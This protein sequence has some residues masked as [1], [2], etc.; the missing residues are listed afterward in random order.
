M[1]ILITGMTSRHVGSER[2]RVKYAQASAAL[3]AVLESVPDEMNENPLLEVEQRPAEVDEDL[4]RFD[5][6]FVGLHDL[7]SIATNTHHLLGVAWA[8]I[9][10]TDKVILH[11][12]DWSGME[13][14]VAASTLVRTWA[15]R[16]PYLR[17]R[18]EVTDHA[19]AILFEFAGMLAEKYVWPASII[20]AFDWADPAKLITAFPATRRSMCWD[21]TRFTNIA[22]PTEFTKERDR[23]RSWVLACLQNPASWLKKLNNVWPIVGCGLK[24]QGQPLLTEMEVR[25]L[26]HQNWGVLAPKYEVPG[27]WRARFYHAAE[28]QAVLLADPSDASQMG[29][30]GGHDMF[31][32]RRWEIERM[33]DVEL[34]RIAEYQ[35]AWTLNNIA[36][37]ERVIEQFKTFLHE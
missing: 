28:A 23:A 9:A 4:S 19:A 10:F 2:V 16:L 24:S 14:N 27:W 11:Y 1:K 21:P 36:P 18:I 17:S 7:N 5:K 6:I 29:S 26:Y 37:R 22:D 34:R 31:A 30:D 15:K 8:C 3:R 32:Y 12:D 25:C 33:S 35:S 20:P 13:V